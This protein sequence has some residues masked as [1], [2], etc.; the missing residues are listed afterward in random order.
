MIKEI[1]SAAFEKKK[2]VF[3]VGYC[4][5][6]SRYMELFSFPI[7]NTNQQFHFSEYSHWSLRDKIDTER[8]INWNEEHVL[9]IPSLFSGTMDS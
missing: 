8:Y 4:P 3:D 7:K 9:V 6:Y 5:P 2:L 1:N